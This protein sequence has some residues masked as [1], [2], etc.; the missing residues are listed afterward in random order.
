M[1]NEPKMDT[2]TQNAD[3]V[4]NIVSMIDERLCQIQNLLYG[5]QTPSEERP[6]IECLYDVLVVTRRTAE[7]ALKTLVSL[8]DRLG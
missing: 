5:I 8:N 2:I 6:K 7:S 3:A 1:M 4:L